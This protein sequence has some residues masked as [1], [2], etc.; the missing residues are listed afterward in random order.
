MQE[1]VQ[2]RHVPIRNKFFKKASVL[3]RSSLLN[4]VVALLIILTLNFFSFPA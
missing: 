3:N 1:C 4:Y 2:A